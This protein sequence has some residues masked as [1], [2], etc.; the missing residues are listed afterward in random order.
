MLPGLG[1]RSPGVAAALALTERERR[2]LALGYD[3]GTPLPPGADHDLSPRNER[4]RELT[5]RYAA[6]DLPVLEHHLWRAGRVAQ[7]VDLRWF[8]GDNLYLWHLPEHPRAMALKLFL[9]AREI[10]DE[11]GRDLLVRLGEDGAFGAWSIEVEGY[12]RLSRDRLDGASEIL[13]LDRRLNILTRPELRVLDV[14]A[15]YG[16]LAHRMTEAVPGLADY[17]CIDAIPEST[18]LCEYYLDHRGARPP[19]R[20]LALDEL[21]AL[22]PEQ[23][24]LAVN[25]HS[26]SECTAAAV[27]WWLAELARLRV[28]H[29][30][31]VPNE[32]RG[33]WSREP[34]G[35]AID[36]APAF[37]EAGYRQIDERPHIVAPAVRDLI[38]VYDRYML[39]ELSAHGLP[40][41]NPQRDS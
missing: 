25:V 37:R 24:D 5:A 10:E 7:H 36:L 28:P 33:V 38:R 13:Y 8:R 21:E 23:F 2:Y 19:A 16:R 20:V 29:L 34:D 9:Y 35:G 11:G 14:G 31:V 41:A 18:F 15:G 30:F 6:V 40:R 39:F 3:D 12:G 22:A 17:C 26:F 27:R 32:P 1:E 4:L